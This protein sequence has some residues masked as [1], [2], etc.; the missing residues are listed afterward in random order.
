MKLGEFSKRGISKRMQAIASGCESGGVRVK[1][2]E[3][4]AVAR[5]EKLVWNVPYNGLA[6]LYGVNCSV[7]MAESEPLVT[8]LMLEVVNAAKGVVGHTIPGA[9]VETMLNNTR[10]MDAYKPSMMIDRE[11]GRP[12]EVEAIYGE[13]VRRAEA[14]GVDVPKMRWLYEQLKAIDANSKKPTD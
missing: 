10:N 9:F 3:D 13:P 11:M 8:E 6:T 4:L 5:W 2:A 14:A 1:L 12:L 7:L